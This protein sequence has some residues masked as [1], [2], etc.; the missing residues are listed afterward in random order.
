MTEFPYFA[1]LF[2]KYYPSLTGRLGFVSTF[3]FPFLI[4]VIF[5]DLSISK[6]SV[7]VIYRGLILGLHIFSRAQECL[8]L[9]RI[10]TTPAV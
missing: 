7:V 6:L 2:A 9:T 10:I 3:F 8:T 4:L 1:R 5:Y